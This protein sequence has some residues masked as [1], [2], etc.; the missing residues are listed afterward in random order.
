MANR[1][2]AQAF[3][4]QAVSIDLRRLGEDRLSPSEAHIVRSRSSRQEASYR[5]RLLLVGSIALSRVR[6][7]RHILSRRRG[8]KVERMNVRSCDL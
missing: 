3:P 5:T 6:A 8:E 1:E 4:E 7:V 2:S